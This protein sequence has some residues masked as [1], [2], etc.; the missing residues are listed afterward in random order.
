MINS[1]NHIN[2]V[3][4]LNNLRKNYKLTLKKTKI[5]KKLDKNLI[6]KQ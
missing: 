3:Y 6:L 1:L 5:F 4:H 2:L